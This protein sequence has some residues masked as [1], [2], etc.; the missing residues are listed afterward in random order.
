MLTEQELLKKWETLT[1]TDDFMFSQVMHD[2]EICRQVVELILGIRIGKI[3][4]LSTQEKQKTDPDSMAII[5]DVYLR[6]ENKVPE[7][8]VIYSTYLLP[9]FLGAGATKRCW[10]RMGS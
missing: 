3:E 8:L 7:M 6:D 2:E 5:M 10:G 1:F 9:G 4:Y